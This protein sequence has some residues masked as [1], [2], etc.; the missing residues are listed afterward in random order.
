MFELQ[1]DTQLS[2]QQLALSDAEDIF[3]LADTSRPYL[4]EW[5]PWVDATQSPDDTRAFIQSTLD[6]SAEKKMLA[7][8]I[9]FQGRMAGI[10]G[11]EPLDWINSIT[12]LGYWLEPNAQ[13]HG[14]MTKT[15]RALTDYAFTELGFNRVEIRAAPGN[16]KSRAIPERL[17]FTQEGILRDAE[18]LYDHFVDIIVYAMLRRD[19]DKS[20]H[21]TQR[22]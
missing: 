10:I 3:A 8:R 15:C 13:G 9:S 14:I 22:L 5:L 16:L 1:I 21:E 17:G 4:R 20:H 11:M 19:W 2:V 7:C 6:Q 18:W 12:E